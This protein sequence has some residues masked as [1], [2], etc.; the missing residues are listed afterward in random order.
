MG[1]D[2]ELCAFC[3]PYMNREELRG[4]FGGVHVKNV[5][6]EREVRTFLRHVAKETGWSLHEGCYEDELQHLCT[7]TIEPGDDLDALRRRLIPEAHPPFLNAY[8]LRD[9]LGE[10]P[11]YQDFDCAVHSP[12]IEPVQFQWADSRPPNSI[13]AALRKCE[14]AGHY[15]EV[16]FDNRGGDGCDISI[17]PQNERALHNRYRRLLIDAR[18]GGEGESREPIGVVLRV[19]NGYM[20]HWR[21][22]RSGRNPEVIEIASREF[23]SP[24]G[25]DLETSEWRLFPAD[26]TGRR[27]PWEKPDLRIICSI[28]L[29]LGAY[30]EHERHPGPGKSVLEIREIRFES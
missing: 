7:M 30:V 10:G 27:A 26:G 16:C 24:V 25:I 19:V 14:Q 3:L 23:G 8:G 1:A 13:R 9:E 20:Q 12:N 22:H 17:R 18:V 5:T 28:N 4:V 11:V 21:L 15:L 2:R 6:D 29:A